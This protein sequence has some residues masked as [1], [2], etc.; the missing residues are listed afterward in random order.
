MRS[1]AILC[2]LVAIG[3]CSRSPPRPA[4][5][6]LTFD[7]Q[8]PDVPFVMFHRYPN[9]PPPGQELIAGPIVALWSDGRI[10]RVASENEIGKQYLEGRLSPEQLKDVLAYIQAR[11]A[12]LR[13]SHGEVVQDAASEYLGIRL[14]GV[15]VLYGETVGDLEGIL[16]NPDV[17]ALRAY[18]LS[19]P[20][21][22]PHPAE[23]PWKV[24]PEDWYRR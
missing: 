8:R 1:I 17:A 21:T 13:L 12:L 14:E 16:H 3:G 10:A 23:A 7:T 19:L 5:A 22:N 6:G 18:L 11:S 24:L 20:M 9:Y 2:V 15:R 4:E